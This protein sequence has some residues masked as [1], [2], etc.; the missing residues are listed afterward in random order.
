MLRVG[1]WKVSVDT[2]TRILICNQQY[3]EKTK[4]FLKEFKAF[5]VKGN[6]VD[7]AVAVVIG[8]AF[9]KIVS[10][11]VD[12]IIMPSIGLLLGGVDFTKWAVVL[13][14]ATIAYGKFIQAVID[15]T[16]I[17]FVIFLAIRIRSRVETKPEK[18]EKQKE[19]SEEVL[20]LREIRDSLKK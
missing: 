5:A 3:M 20:L 17:A 10:S 1:K 11:L 12:T 2:R 18:E 16:I 14:D 7:L 6:V 9:G 4:S 13:G 15:F 8:G 19:P